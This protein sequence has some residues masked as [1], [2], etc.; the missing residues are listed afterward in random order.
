[1]VT[2]PSATVSTPG[3]PPSLTTSSAAA[4]PVAP[5]TGFA[6]TRKVAPGT[7]RWNWSRFSMTS[8]PQVGGTEM[9]MPPT[10]SSS[11]EDTESPANER[12]F[13]TP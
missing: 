8:L 13:I 5:G 6:V 7:S 1:M 10:K 3:V 2:T 11:D 4:A 12:T 9:P